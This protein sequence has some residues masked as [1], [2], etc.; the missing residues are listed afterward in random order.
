MSDMP[1]QPDPDQCVLDK[2]GQLKDTK[3]IMFFHSPS[4]NSPIPLLPVDGETGASMDNRGMSHIPSHLQLLEP[5]RE[6][7]LDLRYQPNEYFVQ[8][9][10]GMKK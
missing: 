8:T 1:P 5:V 6:R 7:F 2:N 9:L 4:D 3:Y 10:F